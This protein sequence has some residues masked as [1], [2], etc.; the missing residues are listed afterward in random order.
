M[1]RK[2]RFLQKI[3]HAFTN[4][5]YLV[6]FHAHV[7]MREREILVSEALRVIQDGEIVEFYPDARPYPSCLILGIVDSKPIH[8]VCALSPEGIGFLV[9]AYI[10]SIEEWESDYRRRKK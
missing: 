8:V 7:K 2:E 9:T 4:G 5:K 3:R 1:I 10:P 6:R